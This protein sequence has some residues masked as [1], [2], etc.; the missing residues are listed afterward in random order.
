M[1][2]YAL[3]HNSHVRSLSAVALLAVLGFT[4]VALAAD[5]EWWARD[6]ALHFLASAT[7]AGGAYAAG[8]L[9]W[10][11]RVPTVGFALGV[12]VGV[13]AAKECWD[14]LGHGDASWKD[15]AWDVVGALA[16]VGL[17]FVVDTAVRPAPSNR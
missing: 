8:T 5:D 14:G 17:S 11:S 9:A 3:V 10:N 7:I 6:K 2:G 16:G 15:F 13:G 4:R 1:P 12:S